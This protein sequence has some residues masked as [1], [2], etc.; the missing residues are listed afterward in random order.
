MLRKVLLL[1]F[2]LLVCSSLPLSACQPPQ[3]KTVPPAVGE[4]NLYN[5]DPITLD[6]AVS[7][8]MTSHEYIMQIF[9]GLVRLD[10]ALKVV[11]DIA[12]EWEV[13]NDGE[14]YTFYLRRDA[15]FHEYFPVLVSDECGNTGPDF[16]Q[17]ATIWNVT[18][19]FGWVTTTNDLTKA[20]ETS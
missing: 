6:P 4:L 1:V 10:T 3:V 16:I 7:G 18:S 2:S 12:E 20:I 5:I 19:V 11:P 13:S 8:E 9:N 17:E 15:Y 14:T